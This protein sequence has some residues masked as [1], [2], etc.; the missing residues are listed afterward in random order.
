MSIRLL[1]LIAFIQCSAC[2]QGSDKPGDD[3]SL[4]GAW[5]SNVEFD[6]GTLASMKGF[7][8]MYVF[9]SGGTMTESSNFDAAP[10]VPPAYGIW[11]PLGKDKYEAQ[12][13]FFI[14]RPPTSTEAQAGVVGW[15]PG[16]RGVLVEEI[17]VS[18][19]G[20]SF[21]STIRYEIL[22]Q[23]GK[24]VDGGGVGE[25]HAARMKFEQIGE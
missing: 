18:A 25:A 2:S 16:G 20:D 14:T 3:D 11:R 17:T 9:N 8:F 6:T 15:L 23:A 21:T 19:D 7:E 1:L 4:L 5:R 12:Y 24:T 22:D 10:P 13:E